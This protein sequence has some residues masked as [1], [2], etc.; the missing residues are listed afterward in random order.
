M[1]RQ[2]DLCALLLCALFLAGLRAYSQSV[3]Q[4]QPFESL[5]LPFSEEEQ[6]LSMDLRDY[7]SL[8]GYDGGT[9]VR[10]LSNRGMIHIEL[11]DEDAPATVSNFLNYVNAGRYKESII[12]RS[13]GGFILQGGGFTIREGDFNPQG[14]PLF[15]SIPNEFTPE[16][17]NVRGTVSMAKQSDDPDSATSQFFFNLSDNSENLNNQ[18]GGFT[19]FAKVVGLGMNTV[20]QISRL[21]QWNGVGLFGP[22]FSDLPLINYNPEDGEIAL[23]SW[24]RFLEFSEA[25]LFPMGQVPGL[26]G[27]EVQGVTGA[28][29]ASVTVEGSQLQ[30]TIPG[31]QTGRME[32]GLVFR[33]N[34]F[35][36]L[37][38][39]EAGFGLRVG[40]LITDIELDGSWQFSNW[41]GLYFTGEDN[42]IYHE[43]LGWLLMNRTDAGGGVFLYTP[44]GWLWTREDLAP[45]FWRPGSN[46]EPGSWL[47]WEQS[48]MDPVYFYDF[49]A[50]G[51]AGSWVVFE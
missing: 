21:T 51:G 35:E 9:L 10:M 37:N 13:I 44:L 34:G 29:P 32:L 41:F 7:V 43:R 22:A 18:N 17:S 46:E 16:N 48:S 2:S 4:T 14:I 3:V 40:G 20:S 47:Y 27:V 24:V 8:E 50:N 19:V 11:L 23:S 28:F 26:L 6:R 1:C 12:H 39:V 42:W 30:L 5:Y 45:Y 15:S 31:R 36:E 25:E 33:E 49:V 38:F